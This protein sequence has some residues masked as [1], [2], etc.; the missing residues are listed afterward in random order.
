MQY[1]DYKQFFDG[2]V[3]HIYNRGHNKMTV[4]RDNEDYKF[5]LQRLSEILSLQPSKSRWLKPLPRG[6]FSVLSF[7]LMPNHFHF[8]IRQETKLSTSKLIGKLLTTYGVYFNKK[9]K[10]VGTVFQDRFKSKEVDNDEYLVPLS[11][12][13]NH[14]PKNFFNWPFSSLPYYLGEDVG[15]LVD[16]SLVLNMF[17]KK[18][19]QHEQYRKYIKDYGKSDKAFVEDLIFEE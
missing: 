2:G 11:A 12:Y 10:H 5:F 16:P 18:R 6:S 19:E 15:V 3:Y 9:Y 4:F 1:R 17:E 7:C 13:I 14:N 8:M